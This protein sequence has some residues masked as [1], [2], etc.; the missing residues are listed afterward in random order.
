[1]RHIQD[2]CQGYYNAIR[3]QHAERVEQEEL[4][5]ETRT[6]VATHDED[7]GSVSR[8]NWSLKASKHW[9]IVTFSTKKAYMSTL[10][11]R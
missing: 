8:Q 7:L 2:E 10:E 3:H 6:A 5:A 11:L 9:T 1:M 4:I